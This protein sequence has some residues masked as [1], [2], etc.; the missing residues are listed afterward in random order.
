MG[1]RE[2]IGLSRVAISSHRTLLH[3]AADSYSHSL[4]KLNPAVREIIGGWLVCFAVAV[5]CFGCLAAIA[6]ARDGGTTVVIGLDGVD[7]VAS[8]TDRTLTPH[9]QSRC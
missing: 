3:P 1:E 6:P 5:G 7:M 2:E 8:N 4:W 9:R